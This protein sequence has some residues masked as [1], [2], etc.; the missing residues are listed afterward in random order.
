MGTDFYPQ[1]NI[2]SSLEKTDLE[3]KIKSATGTAFLV[4]GKEDHYSYA[5]VVSESEEGK[6]MGSILPVLFLVIG[7]LTMVTTMHRIAA[8]EK[9]QI[10]TLKALGFRDRKILIHYTSYGFMVGIL[11]TIFGIILGYLIAVLVISPKGM[12][13]TYLDLPNWDIYMPGFCIPV[14]I[15]ML[16]F[17][18]GISYLS[19]KKMLKGTAAE[20]LRP[21]APKEMKKG[22][23]EYLP[24]WKKL[25]FGTRWNVRDI[26]RHKSRSAMTLFGVIGCT[27]LLV[28]GLDMKDTMKGFLKML[29]QDISNYAT[30]ITLSESAK[31]D[32]AKVLA[33]RLEGDWQ[34][35]CGISYKG[36]T[37]SL[38]I[39]HSDYDKIRFF[40]EENEPMEL[41]DEGVYL[42]LRLKNTADIGDVI[43]ISPYGSEKTY[44][45]QVA[46]YTRS[47]VS[48]CM[49]M[50]DTMAESLGMEYTVDT[51]Y[52]D[53]PIEKIENSK[54]IAGKQEKEKIMDS[55]DTFMDMMNLM[56]ALLV[57]GAVVLGIVVLYNLGVMSY[58]ERYRELAT[59]KVLGFRD[60]DIGKLLISQNIW[61]SVLGILL[62]IPAGIGVLQWL[63]YALA[64]EYEL[65]ISIGWMTY[66]ISTVLTLGVS[67][68]VGWMIAQKNQ[69]IN[70]VEA[71]K[72][73]E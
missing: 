50:T 61:L 67:F 21:Y 10:G 51:I 4:S 12:M 49:V 3:E 45:V 2:I 7:G 18:T 22:I 58:V 9:V 23:L 30:K 56:V 57:L 14:M 59:L 6:T 13:S 36:K 70:M 37:V 73:V 20:V 41:S 65:R 66:G 34:A 8:Q 52:T 43:E 16:F 68:F 39:Y 63:I 72:D 28:G 60:K 11:G 31:N 44:Q 62:G 17:L 24:F 47:L 48:E 35:S 32:Q 38:D 5:G 29:D 69:K 19:V 54:I 25:S 71:L 40:T 33:D 53:L 1:I 55:Y 26:M 46:G 15:G 64:S 42:C 27:I